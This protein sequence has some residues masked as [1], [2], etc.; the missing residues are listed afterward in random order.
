MA[1]RACDCREARN[2]RA[3]NWQHS[4]CTRWTPHRV[5]RPGVGTAVVALLPRCRVQR[6]LI[7]CQAKFQH[8]RPLMSHNAMVRPSP[9]PTYALTHSVLLSETL[10]I[11]QLYLHRVG[12]ILEN[13]HLLHPWPRGSH[14][15]AKVSDTTSENYQ[16]N[17]FLPARLWL[18]S[19]SCEPNSPREQ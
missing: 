11:R 12:V 3:S 5:W 10:L 17:L 19:T 6:S 18:L 8:V 7:D 15:W 14:I 1:K 13:L 16:K 9:F 4:W 2:C